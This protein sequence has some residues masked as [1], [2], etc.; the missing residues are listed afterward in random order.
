MKGGSPPNLGQ[1]GRDRCGRPESYSITCINTVPSVAWVPL[2]G[3]FIPQSQIR[4]FSVCKIFIL[5]NASRKGFSKIDSSN[6]VGIFHIECFFRCFIFNTF[7][8]VG[9]FLKLV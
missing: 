2:A 4:P 1:G 9:S 5:I 3:N 8:R 6:I 7:D